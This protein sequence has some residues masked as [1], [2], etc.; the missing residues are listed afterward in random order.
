MAWP[1]L[2]DIAFCHN[3]IEYVAHLTRVEEI[4]GQGLFNQVNGLNSD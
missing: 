1:P 3:T 2:N 4:T